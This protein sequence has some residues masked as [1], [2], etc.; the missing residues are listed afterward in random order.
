MTRYRFIGKVATYRWNMEP[1]WDS[2]QHIEIEAETL[3]LAVDKAQ[4]ML[5]ERDEGR[6]RSYKFDDIREIPEP[7]TETI[8]AEPAIDGSTSDG[9]HT[10]DELY[11]YRMLYHAWAVQAWLAAGYPVVKSACHADGQ[12][13]FGGGWFIVTAQLPTGQVSNHY[14]IDHWNLFDCPVVERAPEWDGHTPQIAADR[15][16]LALNAKETK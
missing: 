3:D 10:F 15:I 7:V 2:A 12:T 16:A 9:Y 8:A 6:T 11:R 4:A 14:G 13:C 1:D 5:P